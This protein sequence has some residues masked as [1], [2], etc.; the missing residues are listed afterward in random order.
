M[1]HIGDQEAADSVGRRREKEDL[2]AK[3][4]KGSRRE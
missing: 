1:S 2:E 3:G 4:R